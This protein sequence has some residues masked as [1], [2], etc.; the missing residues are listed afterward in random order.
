MKTYYLV[1][2]T[3]FVALWIMFISASVG[4]AQQHPVTQPAA[5]NVFVPPEGDSVPMLDFGGRPVVEVMINGKGPYRF[6]LDTG[7]TVNVIDSSIATEIGKLAASP[8][9]GSSIQELRVGKVVV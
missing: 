1:R 7:A 9:G 2:V 5:D 8:T 6:I 3:E 4:L